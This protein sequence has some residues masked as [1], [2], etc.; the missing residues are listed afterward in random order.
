[1]TFSLAARIDSIHHGALSIRSLCND[2]KPRRLICGI[3]EVEWAVLLQD[4]TLWR[5]HH[6][7]RHELRSHDFG[8]PNAASGQCVGDVLSNAEVDQ[9]DLG[10]DTQCVRAYENVLHF[11]ITMEHILA[12]DVFQA[13]DNLL[14]DAP[15]DVFRQPAT[16]SNE[17]GKLATLY[18]LHDHHLVLSLCGAWAKRIPTS[19]ASRYILMSL[20]SE[21]HV[22]LAIN[23]CNFLLT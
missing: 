20:D 4:Y 2:A 13:L 11:Q 3:L 19:H 6:F 17:A 16:V 1:M 12:V 14:H 9:L 8:S 15:S 7:C 10:T 21:Q 18:Q 23:C 5:D 22:H